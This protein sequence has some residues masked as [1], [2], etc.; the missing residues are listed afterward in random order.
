MKFSVI[1]A[2][3]NAKN[4]KACPASRPLV[5]IND[6]IINIRTATQKSG[7]KYWFDVTPSFYTK[8]QFFLFAC[9]D[10][11]TVYVFPSIVLQ[12]QLRYAS[13]GGQK[14]VPNSTIF[15]DK[16]ELEAAGAGG[17]RSSISQYLNAYSLIP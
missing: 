12:Q 10:A 11:T 7:S 8:V 16:H 5:K 14:Q 17:K 1:Q 9:G 2:L 15:S 4:V 13:L 3:E 6:N